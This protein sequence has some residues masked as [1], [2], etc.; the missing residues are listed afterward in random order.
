MFQG[1]ER[2]LENVFC[3]QDNEK[4]TLMNLFMFFSSSKCPLGLK[5]CLLDVLRNDIDGVVE[6]MF[7][8]VENQANKFCASRASKNA[9]WSKSL[10]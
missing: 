1:V 6:A 8:G 3:I 4:A 9:T 2:P 10:K 5:I 7:Q